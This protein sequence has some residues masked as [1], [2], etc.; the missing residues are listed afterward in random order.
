MRERREVRETGWMREKLFN[1]YLCND[2]FIF[3]IYLVFQ[4][5]VIFRNLTTAI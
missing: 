2:L 1:H 3:I 5:K 4:Y